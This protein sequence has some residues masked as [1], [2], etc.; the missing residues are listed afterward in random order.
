MLPVLSLTATH[1]RNGSKRFVNPQL[2]EVLQVV[3]QHVLLHV[4]GEVGMLQHLQ[5]KKEPDALHGT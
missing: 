1:M 4:S 3:A 5:A 2:P